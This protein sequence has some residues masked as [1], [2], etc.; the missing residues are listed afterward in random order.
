[1]PFQA[2]AAQSSR[3][4]K[5]KKAPTFKRSTSTNSPYAD[6][7]HRKPSARPKVQKQDTKDDDEFYG[8]RLEDA[9]L[10]QTLVTDLNLRDVSQA[11]QYARAQM[12]SLIPEASGMN[13]ARTAEILNYRKNLSPIV[14]VAHIQA[15]LNSP[16]TTEREIA[17]LIRGGAVRKIIIPGRGSL[18]EILILVRD[19]ET[20]IRD[21]SSLEESTKDEFIQILRENPTAMAISQSMLKP[22]TAKAVMHAGFLTTS[23]AQRGG[24]TDVYARPGEGLRGTMSSIKYLSKAPSGSIEAVGGSGVLNST[25][26]NKNANAD[27]LFNASNY[28][29]AIPSTGPYLKLLASARQQLVSLLQKYKYKEAPEDLLRERWDGGVGGDERSLAKKSRNEFA[30]VVAGKTRKWKAFWGLRFEWVLAEC[31]GVGM[32]EVFDTRAV[33]RGVRIA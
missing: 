1:M 28:T 21:V 6:L 27:T 23:I 29:I 4:K 3:I 31:V 25:H 22:E 9:G 10:V 2:F 13:S 8:D 24:V 11:I 18:G 15:L 16:T 17:E 33:G 19:M 7:P 30:G 26:G 20:M 32:I 5:T 14:S 12:F